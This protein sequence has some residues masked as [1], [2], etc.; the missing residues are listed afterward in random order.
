MKKILITSMLLFA[1]MANAQQTG[2]KYK[3]SVASPPPPPTNVNRANKIE[4]VKIQSHGEIDA[5]KESKDKG[6]N[7]NQT[8]V[9]PEKMVP[10]LTDTIK[11]PQPVRRK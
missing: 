3:D 8:Q 7:K 10:I 4:D 5:E 11:N 1:L 6:S 9:N 2:T